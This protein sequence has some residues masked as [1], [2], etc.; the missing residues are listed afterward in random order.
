MHSRLTLLDTV[1]V[2]LAVLLMLGSDALD[3]VVVVVLVGGAFR[4]LHAICSNCQP[5]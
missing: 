3:A 1:L 4:S 2:S 5:G